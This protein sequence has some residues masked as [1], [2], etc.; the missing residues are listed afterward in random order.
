MQLI[1]AGTRIDFLGRARPFVAL[2][3]V[4]I[5]AGVVAILLKG[6]NLGI[7]FKGGT[8][9]QIKT[10][11]VVAVQEIRDALGQVNLGDA[12]IQE[13]GSPRDLL[14]R[15]E[16]GDQDLTR[17]VKG[18][19]VDKLGADGVEIEREELV[20]PQVGADLRAKA[21]KAILYALGMV[22]IYIT[23][24]FELKFAVAA[25]VAIIHDVSITLGIFAITG[26]ELDLTVIAALLTIVGYS[27]ND[28]IVVFD[29]IRENHRE[30]IQQ[31]VVKVI[32]PSINETLSRTALTSITTL[33]VVLALFFL[34]GKVIHDFAF[35]LLVGVV[36]GTY[37]SIFIASP[38]V[39]L[40]DRLFDREEELEEVAA[41]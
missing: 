24:R 40:W 15:A 41:G 33:V 2:S 11:D 26:F 36:V 20:G 27:L 17:R 14:I 5:G 7:D 22:V 21:V 30:N 10:R 25:I 12:V 6:L 39:A 29:R 32:N 34:G 13:F 4:V 16:A 18:A 31:P 38:L 1:R 37:S 9:I 35:A 3:L 28:T 19:L 8:L 23:I